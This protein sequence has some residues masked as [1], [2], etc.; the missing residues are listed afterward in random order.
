VRDFL[1]L[2]SLL[3]LF[4]RIITTPHIL[5]QVTDLA[6]TLNRQHGLRFFASL[7]RRIQAFTE[8][9]AASRDVC[10]TRCFVKFGLADASLTELGKRNYLILTDDFPLYGYLMKSRLPALNFNHLRAV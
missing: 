4:S 8:E 3:Q 10:Q 9:C 5:T 7:Q 1:T 6:D 2:F